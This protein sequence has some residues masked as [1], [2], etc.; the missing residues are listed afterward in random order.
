MLLFY[1]YD[2]CA[3]CRNAKA[4]LDRHHLSY[5]PYDITATPPSRTILRSILASG[6]YSLGQ[7]FNRSG[8]LYRQLNM[9]AQLTKLSEAQAVALL[10]Q[11]GKL[12]KRP[13]V[14]DG[15]RHTVGFDASQFAE[16]WR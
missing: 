2:K 14:T 5:K 12:V 4:W 3:T 9:K 15:H 10:A 6:R 1:G 11:H 7:L 8:K 13:V 16:V